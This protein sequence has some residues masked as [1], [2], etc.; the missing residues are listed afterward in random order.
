MCHDVH[1]MKPM[2]TPITNSMIMNTN[3]VLVSAAWVLWIAKTHLLARLVMISPVCE[4]VYPCN[5]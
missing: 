5:L 4:Q 2:A 1:G 3:Y